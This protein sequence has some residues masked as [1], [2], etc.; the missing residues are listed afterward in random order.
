M[1]HAI[2]FKCFKAGAQAYD[3]L[4]MSQFHKT[5]ITKCSHSNREPTQKLLGFPGSNGPNTPNPYS[6]N[7][8]NNLNNVKSGWKNSTSFNSKETNLKKVKQR[9]FLPTPLKKPKSCQTICRAGPSRCG[10]QWRARR[11]T[12]LSNGVMTLS[13]SVN[14]A[15]T[16]LLKMF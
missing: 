11:A 10:V 4:D 1:H 2:L 15:T 12:P 7:S 9:F 14:R 8:P 6:Q 3:M 16:F 5:S 13:R